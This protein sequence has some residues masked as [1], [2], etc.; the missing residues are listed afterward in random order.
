MSYG[1]TAVMKSLEEAAR[2]D[3]H[4]LLRSFHHSERDH[5]A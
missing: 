4:V 1:Q 5:H 3:E 2:P